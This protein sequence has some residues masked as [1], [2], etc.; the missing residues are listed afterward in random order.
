MDVPNMLPFAV[1]TLVGFAALD[2]RW[3]KFAALHGL[4]WPQ[5]RTVLVG[6]AGGLGLFVIGTLLPAA[7]YGFRLWDHPLLTANAF[8]GTALSAVSVAAAL[9]YALVYQAAGE[10]LFFRGFLLSQLGRRLALGQAN[11]LQAGLF[12]LVHLPMLALLPGWWRL[13]I[14]MVFPA[15]LFNGWLRR[16]DSGG[17]LLPPVLCHGLANALT[18][19]LMMAVG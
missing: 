10:E 6:L 8:R 16:L 15:G 9:G 5:A 7:A 1:L 11:L 18:C 17:S 13:S 12:F 3:E 19:V 14:L 2:R 4:T